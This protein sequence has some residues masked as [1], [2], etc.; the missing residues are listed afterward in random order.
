[1]HGRFIFRFD[2]KVISLLSAKA[3]PSTTTTHLP[4]NT[5]L[6]DHATAPC[7]S[8]LDSYIHRANINMPFSMA[9]SKAL[10]VSIGALM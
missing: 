10:V 2:V 1:M 8:D 5:K 6:V 9:N 7:I 3:S 4:V